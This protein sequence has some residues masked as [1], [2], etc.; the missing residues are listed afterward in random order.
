[1]SAHFVIAPVILPA[2]MAGLMVLFARN[3]A[4]QRFGAVLAVAGLIALALHNLAQASLGPTP[5]FL[6][7]WPA[8]FGIVLVLDRLSALMLALVAGLAGVVM[9]YVLATGWD[10]RGAYFHPLFMF[11]LMGLNGAFLTADAFNLFVFFEV[12]LIA[13]YGLM[14]HGVGAERMRAGLQ[15]VAFNLLGSTVFL[16]ALATIYAISGTLNMADLAQKLPLMPPE[17]AALIRLSA[18]LMLVVFA[19]KG[20]LV[21]LQFWLPRSYAAAPAPVAALFAVMT[22]LGAYAMIRFGTLVFPPTLAATGTLWGDILWV[23]GL[24]GIAVGALGVLGAARLAPLIGFAIIGSMGVVVLTLSQ[25]TAPALAAALYYAVHST[26]AAA[27]LFLLADT[28]IARRGGDDLAQASPKM[29]QGGL[30]G[31][32]FMVA[33][34]AMVGLPPLSG[35]VGKV[36]VLQALSAHAPVAWSAILLG[37]LV[38]MIGFARA[39]SAL[40]WRVDT[41]LEVPKHAAQPTAFAAIFALIAAMV[42]LSLFAAPVAGWLNVTADDLMAPQAY[43][44]VQSLPVVAP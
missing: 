2:V 25:F 18:V 10:R 4:L 32:L 22:K 37:T 40:F 24:M 33:A 17:D 3:P 36:Q 9:A 19:I 29:A 38:T 44:N 34:V 27:T 8:P 15:Y 43:I 6:G 20:A 39:G 26:F 12:L 7:N 1:M 5:Y 21:P 31:G 16:F 23:A 30:I 35:F 11:Q 41:A 28:I 42:A 14:V 13:S